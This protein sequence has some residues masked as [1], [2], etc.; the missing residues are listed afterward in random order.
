MNAE[1]AAE[2]AGEAQARGHGHAGTTGSQ[3][4]CDADPR[5]QHQAEE[6]RRDRPG[7][8]RRHRHVLIVDVQ[9]MHIGFPEDGID[10]NA[11]PD[12]AS[13]G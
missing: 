10:E 7:K 12:L 8:P 3:P 5:R 11:I 9:G 4:A 13:R 2:T 6:S 1:V